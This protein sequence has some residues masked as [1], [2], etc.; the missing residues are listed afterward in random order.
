MAKFLTKKDAIIL[1]RETHT[2]LPKG[3]RIARS[4]AWNNF[5]DA[6]R[7]DRCISAHAYNTWTC[8]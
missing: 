5:T 6:L 7:T 4:E 8:P 1:F 2:N 3:D